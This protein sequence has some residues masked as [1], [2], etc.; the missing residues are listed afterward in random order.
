MDAL[1]SDPMPGMVIW[2]GD[3][4]ILPVSIGE[5]L[6]VALGYDG[7]TIIPDAAHFLQEDAGPEIGRIIAHWLHGQT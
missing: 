5:R 4:P 6:A 7:P 1:R 3:D 2:A